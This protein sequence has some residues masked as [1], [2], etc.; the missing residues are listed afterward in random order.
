M[1]PL[2]SAQPQTLAEILLLEKDLI[3]GGQ[4]DQLGDLTAQKERILEQIQTGSTGLHPEDL[5]KIRSLAL[6]NLRLIDAAKSGVQSVRQRLAELNRV[7]EGSGTYSK[8]GRREIHTTKSPNKKII[9]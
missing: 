8:D 6:Q 2:K 1:W 4:L 7:I 5:K 3:L 9:Y